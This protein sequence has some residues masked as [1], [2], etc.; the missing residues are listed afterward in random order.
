MDLVL[1]RFWDEVG[2]A[3]GASELDLYEDLLCENDQDLYAWVSGKA[4]PPERFACLITRIKVHGTAY[5]QLR[6]QDSVLGNR[7]RPSINR[8]A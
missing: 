6:E 5:E 7:S 8:T 2:R 3:L 4:E 1:G